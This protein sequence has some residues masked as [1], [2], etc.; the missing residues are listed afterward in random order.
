MRGSTIQ[1]DSD[2]RSLVAC[3]FRAHI[4]AGV[5]CR[6]F[7]WY[8]PQNPEVTAAA[9]TYPLCVHKRPCTRPVPAWR[10][11]LRNWRDGGGHWRD[12]GETERLL[13]NVVVRVVLFL[14][15]RGLDHHHAQEEA[16]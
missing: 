15:A 4:E 3:A 10:C 9:K 12:G 16:T 2:E 5:P 1:A 11:R 13:H 7:C 14:I 6:I 8:T